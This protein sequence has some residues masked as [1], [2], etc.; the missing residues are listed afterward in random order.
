M[1]S[2]IEGLK[3]KLEVL[4]GAKPDAP[5]DVAQQQKTEKELSERRERVAEAGGQMLT[6]ALGFIGELLPAA[7]STPKSQ[8]LTEQ[9]RASLAECVEQ[10]ED[11]SVRVTLKLKDGTALD[12]LAGVV[13]RL[14]E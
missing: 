5:I 7:E 4:L 13:A 8:Q 14:V 10:G 9:L 11:G 1:V 6:A 2:G 12:D 3:Q